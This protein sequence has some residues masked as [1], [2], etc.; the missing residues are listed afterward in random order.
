MSCSDCEGWVVLCF[1]LHLNLE[2]QI[3]FCTER[4]S[5]VRL[6]S[7]RIYEKRRRAEAIRRRGGCV[8]SFWRHM[9]ER[10]ALARRGAQRPKCVAA[11]RG[12]MTTGGA[13]E[14]KTAADAVLRGEMAGA[15]GRVPGLCK[16]DCGRGRQG[17][18]DGIADEGAACGSAGRVSRGGQRSIPHPGE[19]HLRAGA[20]KGSRP[21]V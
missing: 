11:R 1:L 15:R 3:A 10:H 19:E 5:A 21:A 6:E 7:E 13:A 17:V 14:Q 18:L 12:S 4:R 9:L 20:G 16:K 8:T 2:R